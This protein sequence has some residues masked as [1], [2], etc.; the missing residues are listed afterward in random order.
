MAIFSHKTFVRLY[1]T[2]CAGIL[3]YGRLY[4]LVHEAWEA[5]C[6]VC[7]VDIGGILERRDFLLPIVHVEADYIAPMKM[8]MPIRIDLT[9]AKPGNTSVAFGFEIYSEK[10]DSMLARVRVV[11]VAIDGQTG[12]KIPLPAVIRHICEAG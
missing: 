11:Q 3:F 5:F 8:G 12:G 7:D 10:D 4:E 2:D 1:H 6:L 9:E